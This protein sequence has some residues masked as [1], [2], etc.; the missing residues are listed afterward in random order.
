MKDQIFSVLQMVGRSF[1]LPVAILP[2]AGLLLGVG[3]SFTNPTT[4]QTYGLENVL[5]TGTLLN[6]L[7]TI[8]ASAGNVIFGNLPIIFAVGVAIGMAKQ[9]K[10]VAALAAMIS[11]FVMHASTNA[12]LKLTGKV[13][14]HDAIS[15]DVLEGTIANVC[16]I[17]S[18]QEGV[19][20]GIIV[21]IGVAMLHNKYH[22]IV[23]PN[24]LSFFGG[25]RFVPI[26]ST[27]VFM[28][29]GIIMYFVWP[30][31]QNGIFALGGLVTGTGYVGTLIF[32]IIKRALIPFGLHHVFYLPFWQ[33]GVGGS[34]MID[35]KL[36]QGGQNIF[37]AQL[38]SPDVA[39]F[40][41]DATRYFSGEFIFM[42]FGLPGA[43]LA[44]YRTAKPEKRKVAGGLLLSAA[45]TSML[46]GITEPIEFS[47]LFVA[48]MLFGVQVILAGAAYM[49]AHMLNIAVGL[50]FSGGFLDLFI[51]GILQGEAKTNWMY[52]IPVGI[53]YFFLYYFIFTFLIKKFDFKTPGREDDDTEVKLYTKADVN[54]RKAANAND[55]DETASVDVISQAI[56]RGLGSKQNITSV[57]CCATRLRCSVVNSDIVDEKLLKATGAVGVI[58]KGSGVQ[59]IYGPQV[60]VIKSNLETYLET[61]PDVEPE[62]ETLAPA[63]PPVEEAPAKPAE[64][65]EPAEKHFFNSPFS[66]E[67][68]PITDAPDEAFAAKMTGDGFFVYPTDNTVY[69]PADGTVTFVFD[70]KHA[71]GMT[72]S[73]GT[74]YLLHIG[75]DTVKLNGQGFTV[76]V[77]NGQE[78][79]KG[80]K[81]MEFDDEYIK[82]NAPSD[83][84]LCIFTDLAEGQEVHLAKPGTI[85]ALD[86][87]VWF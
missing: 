38:A 52:I 74:E 55:N 9:E 57:D 1:M 45:L 18:L 50:T 12:V 36:V 30:I 11:F 22:K 60:A 86:E 35:G 84:C 66:G 2:I 6:S 44:M 27:V 41:A 25:S 76:F 40:S 47:F 63:T 81:L 69:A 73:D 26:I 5:G 59:V 61:A 21:G 39:H 33:T 23:L 62:P 85:K 83:A 70:T 24:A 46:T 79:K 42:I 16:G 34:M 58:K 29:V 13:L 37:F 56:A 19:F 78:V 32:G 14:A 65:A 82:A 51:F 49:I 31:A 87:A 15:P 53:V 54:A 3:A 80:D 75:I 7:L 4:I 71:I 8:M 10:E 17:M 43:A 72:S 67:L 77:D 68:R 48:P 20:G 28:F 64:S